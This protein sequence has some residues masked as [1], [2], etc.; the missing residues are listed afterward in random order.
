MDGGERWV[1]RQRR[2]IERC[3]RAPDDG[4]SCPVSV[5]RPRRAEPHRWSM[6]LH[7]ARFFSYIIAPSIFGAVSLDPVKGICDTRLAAT[8][9][10][11]DLFTHAVV[12]APTIRHASSPRKCIGGVT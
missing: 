8:Q 6:L 4:A 5:K 1:K 9:D 10:L 11:S 7:G 12:H 3:L 2:P